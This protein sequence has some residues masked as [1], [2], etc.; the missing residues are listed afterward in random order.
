M[1][2]FFQ[3]LLFQTFLLYASGKLSSI[4][5]PDAV[6]IG[7]EAV[8]AWE[9]DGSDMLGAQ[10]RLN[11]E[12]SISTDDTVFGSILLTL[13]SGAQ[14]GAII[15][16]LKVPA[17][18]IYHFETQED[19]YSDK[20]R[21]SSC[22]PFF[23]GKYK[24]V[25]NCFWSRFIGNQ[26]APST[27]TPT[28][29]AGQ[30]SSFLSKSSS[31]GIESS[32]SAQTS[33][34][35]SSTVNSDPIDTARVNTQSS[36]NQLSTAAL[37]GII[38]SGVLVLVI[39]VASLILFLWSQRRTRYNPPVLPNNS[40]SAGVDP[41]ARVRSWRY[42]TEGFELSVISEG[43]EALPASDATAVVSSSALKHENGR[44]LR[45]ENRMLRSAVN[46]LTQGPPRHSV[47]TS[48]MDTP[49]PSYRP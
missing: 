16:R 17:P 10:Y 46:R 19:I 34:I 23:R 26:Q 31:A 30:T 11:L 1:V 42:S 22:P 9:A 21:L 29:T 37:I 35:S 44:L 48:T 39:I 38:L 33:V 15:F 2:S 5:L 14:A 36:A 20:Q 6:Q 25:A 49:P 47:T 3:L 24:S 40:P 18:G 28:S 12:S 45:Q 13:S 8:L 43:D 7:P 32:E 27:Q 41:L 4:S